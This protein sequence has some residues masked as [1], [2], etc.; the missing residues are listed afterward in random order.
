MWNNKIVMGQQDKLQLFDGKNIRSVW[1]DAD[2]Q[3]Y[4]VLDRI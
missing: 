1:N 2:E 4:F 3:W